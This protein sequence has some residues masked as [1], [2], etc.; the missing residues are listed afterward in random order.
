MHFGIVALGSRGDVQPYI[1][2]ALGLQSAGHRT[3]LVAYE[4][5]KPLAE[6]YGV[7]FRQLSGNVEELLHSEEGRRILKTGNALSLL[8]Y[9]AR[10]ARDRWEINS[11]ELLN[12]CE[13]I[14]AYITS[15]L[16]VP[17]VHSIAEKFR[18]P[19]AIV[20]L[21]FPTT[22]TREF[23]F[24]GLRMLNFPAYNLLTYRLVHGLFWRGS[25]RGVNELRR[26]LGLP[27]LNR[28]P[29]E[30]ADAAGVLNLYAVSPALIRRPI[31]WGDHT[32]I[33][34][35]L[36]IS[37]EGKELSPG[38]VKWLAAGEPP[39]YIGFGS[40]PVPDPE[41]FGLMM[42]ELL[43]TTGDRY[44]FCEG[45]SAITGLPDDPRLYRVSYAD[46]SLLFPL[47]KAVVIHGGIGTI[48]AALKAGV[49][50]VVVSIFGDQGW[51]GR[52][53]EKKEA[54]VHVPFKKLTAVRL[55]KGITLA[56]SPVRME[57][58]R[59]LGEAVNSEDGVGAAVR[60]MGVYFSISV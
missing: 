51:W 30:I 6:S 17:W 8:R 2:L 38:L 50:I 11:Q 5:F 32:A 12:D 16:G 24:E 35:F 54:G 7:G 4:N 47:C 37:G 14:K 19:W 29:G 13:E 56:T 49:P 23:P 43:A 44:L 20:Q 3:T 55:R 25:K 10:M 41:R 52:L 27:K 53:L 15:P 31:D 46:H 22:P 1:A 57:R 42:K 33:T 48:A 60:A 34:G 40:M 21:S 26:S 18:L 59:V 45:W 28:P 58:L 36:M 39:V 9:L